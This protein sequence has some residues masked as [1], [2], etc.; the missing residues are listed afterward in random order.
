VWE[1]LVVEEG[2]NTS[3]VKPTVVGVSLLQQR[4]AIDQV[5][6]GWCNGL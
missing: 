3:N 4:A 5:L 6:G 2:R 1:S